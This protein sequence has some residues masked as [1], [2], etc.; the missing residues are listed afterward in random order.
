MISDADSMQLVHFR[1]GQCHLSLEVAR[2]VEVIRLGGIADMKR[3][4]PGV[5]GA[6]SLHGHV[7]PVIQ[8]AKIL[9]VQG[10][11]PK[12]AVVARGRHLELALGV[13]KVIGVYDKPERTNDVPGVVAVEHSVVR[14]FHR[15][16]GLIIGWMDLEKIFSE[17]DWE[18]I[19]SLSEIETDGL[20]GNTTLDILGY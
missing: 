10:R 14:E 6:I 4:M 9:D 8:L 3:H 15:I 1:V 20:L 12:H 7:V 16:D 13:D 11:T 17:H 19:R 18:A 2:V 5:Q